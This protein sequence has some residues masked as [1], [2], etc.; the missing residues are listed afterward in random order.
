M[1]PRL[2]TNCSPPSCSSS[3]PVE[4]NKSRVTDGSPGCHDG[5]AAITGGKICVTPSEPSCGETNQYVYPRLDKIN[6][7]NN[8]KQINK[9]KPSNP[10]GLCQQ[11]L[12]PGV[13]GGSCT[14]TG[15]PEPDRS[16]LATAVALLLRALTATSLPSGH[17]LGMAFQTTC[18]SG[19]SPSSFQRLP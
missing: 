8:K 3:A 9:T 10:E 13:C 1:F 14:G 4:T 18:S 17:F 6:Q 12:Q 19:T 15:P 11:Q 16:V 2:S 7:K 5:Q